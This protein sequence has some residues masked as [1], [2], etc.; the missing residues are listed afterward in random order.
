MKKALPYILFLIIPLAIV[1]I[2]Y[3]FLPTEIPIQFTFSG[4]RYGN[5]AIL[6][7]FALIPFAIYVARQYKKK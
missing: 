1:S 3:I 7:A 2:A 4:I 5:K 6:F